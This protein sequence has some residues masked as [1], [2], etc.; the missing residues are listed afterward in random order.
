MQLTGW[1]GDQQNVNKYGEAYV[2]LNE[3]PY[4]A[5]TRGQEFSVYMTATPGGVGNVFAYLANTSTNVFVVDT[6]ELNCVA[7]EMFNLSVHKAGVTG[8]ASASSAAVSMSPGYATSNVPFD[9]QYA[10]ALTL[11]DAA[12][13]IVGLSSVTAAKG[14]TSWTPASR[15]R[16]MPGMAMSV[17]ALVS[18][19]AVQVVFRGFVEC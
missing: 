5:N 1:N 14:T 13:V 17:K 12:P 18:G 6:V 19:N 16:L 8:G 11:D 3:P 2:R 7:A 10:A 4:A 15:V 9:A